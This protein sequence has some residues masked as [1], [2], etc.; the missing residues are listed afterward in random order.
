MGTSLAVQWLRFQAPNTG[1]MGWT[2][3]WETKILHATQCHQKKKI[4]ETKNKKYTDN[5]SCNKI[6][7]SD[8]GESWLWNASKLRFHFFTGL[9][10]SSLWSTL[11]QHTLLVSSREYEKEISIILT[12]IMASLSMRTLACYSLLPRS[13][14][15]LRALHSLII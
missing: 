2:P 11:W 3:G 12:E 13:D 15:G 4:Q 6:M 1:I 5:S 8:L 10:S 9:M 14:S 7:K